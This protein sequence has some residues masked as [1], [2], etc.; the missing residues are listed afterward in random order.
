[1]IS[2]IIPVYNNWQVTNECLTSLFKINNT[3]PPFDVIVIDNGSS[4]EQLQHCYEMHPLSKVIRNEENLGYV[5]A[6]NQGIDYALQTSPNGDI[7]LMN[8]DVEVYDNWLSDMNCLLHS[9]SSIG[10]VGATSDRLCRHY[11]ATF[12]LVIIKNKVFQKI[13]KLSEEYGIGCFD[14]HDF[15]LR[16]ELDGWELYRMPVKY[17]HKEHKTIVNFNRD[18]LIKDNFRIFIE[19][20]IPQ[21][22]KPCVYY[23]LKA[24]IKFYENLYEDLQGLYVIDEDKHSITITDGK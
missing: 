19:K 14:D 2:I 1:M 22:S 15:C 16:A 13:G 21:I 17:V 12:D 7:V 5:K 9:N 8:N 4:E 18:K 11:L 10:L 23:H 24:V 6:V 3:N 20:F